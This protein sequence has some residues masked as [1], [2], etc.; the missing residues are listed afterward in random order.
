MNSAPSQTES[1]SDSGS[2]IRDVWDHPI[3]GVIARAVLAAVV[4]LLGFIGFFGSLPSSGVFLH[5]GCIGLLYSLMG[6]GIILIY[7]ANRIINFAQ[8]GMGSVAAL[9][10]I[11]LYTNRE[12]PFIL[13]VLLG[14]ASAFLTGFVIETLII[15][16]F[17]K[18]PRLILTVATIGVAQVLVFLEF[19]VPDWVGGNRD[20]LVASGAVNTPLRVHQ[21]QIGGIIFTGDHISALIAVAGIGLFLAWFLTRTRL[22]MAVRASAENAE[23]AALLGI[24]IARV[25]TTVWV[26]AAVMSYAGVMLRI[27]IVNSVPSGSGELLSTAALLFGLAPAVIARMDRL[28]VAFIAGP[29][30]GIV[31]QG[32]LFETRNSNLATALMLPIILG[33]LLLQSKTLSRSQDTG[34][35][36]WQ[37][38]REFRPI[39]TEM[40]HLPEVKILRWAMR[41][42]FVAFMVFIPFVVNELRIDLASQMLIYAITGVSLVILMGWAGQISLGQFAF[43]GIGAGVAGAM[44]ARYGLPFLVSILIGGLAGTLFSV[45][46]GLPALR[47]PGLYLAV[48]TL[49]L[50]QN[51]QTYFLNPTYYGWFLQESGTYAERPN[52]FGWY[53]F[54]PDRSYY[55]L[56]LFF[57][58]LAMLSARSLRQHRGGRLLIAARDNSRA[59]Q[60]FGVHLQRSKLAAFAISGFFA[61]V[62]GGLFVHLQGVTKSGVFP[63]E[64]GLK[65][66][67]LVVIGGVTSVG[68]AVIGAVYFI[69][70]QHFLPE[71]Q[72]LA[73]GAG[74][75]ILLL[76][77]PGGLSEV[78]F[79]LRDAFLRWRAERRDMYV[80]SLVADVLLNDEERISISRESLLDTSDSQVSATSTVLSAYS[81]HASVETS[82][83]RD[84]E[85]G[86]VE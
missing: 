40:L 25:G 3:L 85:R 42:G 35:T 45:A 10:T 34:V 52:L 4:V 54:K 12:W 73:T 27:P 69:G 9:A 67:A 18:A 44:S 78:G 55:Y 86:T 72:I 50:A 14:L 57:L 79:S 2:G 66:F 5:G 39:P 23:R 38:V 1:A 76:F 41:L 7:R 8:A 59:A 6:M 11:L 60:A 26:I 80:P 82:D 56:C 46:V 77:F 83:I 48:T 75:L 24:P 36:T 28:G 15:R 32:I 31:D 61:A 62:A 64:I 16:R 47:L 49:L 74:M 51:V 65:V 53:D 20:P 17:S 30:I 37:Q 70:F 63:A 81:D 13:A 22:G 84:G 21:K 33:A 58:A 43:V 19:R 71:Y 68:G 29:F